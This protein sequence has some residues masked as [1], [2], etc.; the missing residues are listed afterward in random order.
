M[1]EERKTD[2]IVDTTDCLEAVSAFKAMK[3]FLF[4]IIIICLLLL[5]GA[6]WLDYTGCIDRT[7]SGGLAACPVVAVNRDFKPVGRT[8]TIDAQAKLATKDIGDESGQKD[9]TAKP[10]TVSETEAGKKKGLKMKLSFKDRQIASLIKGCNFIL[11]IAATLYSLILLVSVKISLVGRLGEIN[12]IS[13]A[14]FLSLFALVIL[15]PWQRCFSGVITGAIYAPEELFQ[16][17]PVAIE[18]SLIDQIL[19]YLRFTG[20]WLI[21]TLLII[22]AQF[23]SIR[24][25]KATLRRLGILR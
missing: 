7:D 8:D 12:H 4:L 13:R 2:D 1:D 17:L 22:F 15:L 6:F 24:W 10:M 9:E 25:T 3:D 20:L 18:A 11:I 23:R 21:A 16:T 5:E 14:F 19:Y